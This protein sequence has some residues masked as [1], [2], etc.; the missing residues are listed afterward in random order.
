MY[1][2]VI[3]ASMWPMIMDCFSL[4]GISDEAKSS[5]FGTRDNNW[6]YSRVGH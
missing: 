1:I 6:L 4:T 3:S 5:P 2:T